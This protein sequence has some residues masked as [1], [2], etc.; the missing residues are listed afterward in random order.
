MLSSHRMRALPLAGLCLALLAAD[1]ARAALDA[2]LTL[3][4]ETQ[5]AIQGGVTARGRE[6]RILVVAFD[7]GLKVPPDGGAS[8]SVVLAAYPAEQKLSLI[9]LV[10]EVTGLGLTE[11]KALVE[12]VPKPVKEGVSQKE[13]VSARELLEKAG[14]TVQIRP[15][16]SAGRREHGLFT[17]R[18]ELD[19]STPLLYRA[20][21]TNE[22]LAEF[23]LQCWRP[24]LPTGAE[25]QYFTIRLKNAR[26][27]GI[28]QRMPNTANPQLQGL[29]T[30][31]D[32][33]F[34]Y[35][36][37]TWTWTDGGVTATDERK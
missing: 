29:E 17:L 4:G 7:H 18:K 6:N 2:Y 23:E 30:Y 13:A 35:D 9:R 14:A 10:R 28:R 31:E 27:V 19:R 33:T 11:A 26:V 12:A 5:G 36:A 37:I 1:P 34:S 8:Y 20:L 32:V 25:Q 22:T 24:S 21:S 3:K 15:L 16:S